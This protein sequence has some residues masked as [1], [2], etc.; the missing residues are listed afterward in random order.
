MANERSASSERLAIRQVDGSTPR[1]P[2]E[3]TSFR[4]AHRIPDTF[5]AYGDGRSPELHW[6]GVPPN[7]ESLVLL[8][9]DPDAPQATPWV[10][11]VLYNLPATVDRVPE[12][13]A[14]KSRLDELGGAMQGRS[15]AGEIGYYGP[16]PPK[17]HGTHHYHFELFALDSRLDLQP[18][19]DRDGVVR[20]MRGHVLA[21]GELVGTYEAS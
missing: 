14:T 10:H 13:V 21:C 15:S 12:A 7:T 8:V 9:E 6:A 1:V 4:P 20:A 18:G 3:S 17:G 16:R 5:S 19:A 2:I 11:W